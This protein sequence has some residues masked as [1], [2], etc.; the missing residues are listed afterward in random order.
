MTIPGVYKPEKSDEA[1]VYL[2]S[3]NGVSRELGWKCPLI[4]KW[5]NMLVL[6]HYVL[7]NDYFFDK[8]N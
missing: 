5:M 6:I 1:E 3:Q 8:Q 4:N 2:H 7:V